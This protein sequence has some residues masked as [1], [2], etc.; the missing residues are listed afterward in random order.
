MNVFVPEN[1]TVKLYR[2]PDGSIVAVTGNIVPNL[3]VEVIDLDT[4]RTPSTE[5]LTKGMPFIHFLKNWQ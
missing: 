4:Y 3:K 5:E 2:K 1:A